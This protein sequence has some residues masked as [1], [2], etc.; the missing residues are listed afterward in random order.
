MAEQVPMQS[1]KT[2]QKN[3]LFVKLGSVYVVGFQGPVCQSIINTK[4]SD[5]KHVEQKRWCRLKNRIEVE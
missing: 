3:I 4:Q 5:G 1:N 2:I